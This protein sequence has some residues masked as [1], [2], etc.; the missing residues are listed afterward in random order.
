ME[1]IS[2]LTYFSSELA[3][4]NKV[5]LVKAVLSYKFNIKHSSKIRKVLDDFILSKQSL[6]W[7]GRDLIDFLDIN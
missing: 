5:E 2:S 1:L 7:V 3:N 4:I 6:Y